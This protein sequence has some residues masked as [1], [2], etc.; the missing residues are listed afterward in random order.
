VT[1]AL[2]S[3]ALTAGPQAAR[4]SAPLRRPLRRQRRTCTNSPRAWAPAASCG[5]GSWP[6]TTADLRRPAV[7]PAGTRRHRRRRPQHGRFPRHHHRHRQPG[8]AARP[9]PPQRDRL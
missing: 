2:P 3:I 1:A 7:L 9:Q 5:P 6:G 4:T 8:R